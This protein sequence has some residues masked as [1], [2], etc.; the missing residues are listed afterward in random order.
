MP[1]RSDVSRVYFPLRSNVGWF[2]SAGLKQEISNRIKESLLVFD[3]LVFED[4]TFAANIFESGIASSWFPPGQLPQEFR[5]VEVQDVRT[6]EVTI[7]MGPEG[8]P[9][10]DV[11]FNGSAARLKVDYYDIF[12]GLDLSSFEFIK[13]IVVD[14][15]LLSVETKNLISSN[16]FHDKMKFVDDDSN[17]WF[18]NLVADNIN[19]DIVI[20]EMLGAGLVIDATHGDLLRKKSAVGLSVDWGQNQHSTVVRHLLEISVPN[21]WRCV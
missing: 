3:E 19:R 16:A 7:A 18:R 8:G 17:R 4:G 13:K 11:V 9:L 20:S 15:S 12:R 21:F 6:E 5:T 14:D 2:T 10:T 1:S